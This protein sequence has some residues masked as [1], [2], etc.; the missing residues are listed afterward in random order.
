M[1]E[2]KAG[3]T[4]AENDDVMCGWSSHDVFVDES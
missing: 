1:G 3:K 2:S 4:A